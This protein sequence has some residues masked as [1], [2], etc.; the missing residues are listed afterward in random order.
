MEKQLA[1]PEVVL[2]LSV[3]DRDLR[4]F[5]TEKLKLP[6]SKPVAVASASGSVTATRGTLLY[7]DPKQNGEAFGRI[8]GVERI[9]PTRRLGVPGYD[10]A[11][12]W[13]AT[14]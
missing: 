13:R 14:E 1:E 11:P 10:R 9:G 12:H 8:A 2:G 6:I 3:G 5:A 7:P 4:E